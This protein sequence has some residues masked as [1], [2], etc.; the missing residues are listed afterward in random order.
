[1]RTKKAFYN[2]VVSITYQLVAL[3]CGLIVPRMLLGAFGSTYNGVINSVAQFLSM[4]SILRLG[5]AGS[6]RVALY[7]T[8]AEN[9]TLGTSRLIKATNRYARKICLAIVFLSVLL[10]VFYPMISNNDLER[11]QTTLLIFIVSITT[12]A[13]YFFGFTYSTLLQADQ[14]EYVYSL[15]HIVTTILNAILVIILIRLNCNVFTVKFGSAIAYSLLPVALS[16]Y[17]TKKYHITSDCE[18]DDSAL[19]KRG[20]VMF[21]SIANIVHGN[22]DIVLLTLFLDAKQ[23]SVYTVYYLVIGKIR[24]LTQVFTSGL[25]AA[26]GNMWAKNETAALKRNFRLYEFSMFSFVSVIFSCVGL[27]IVPF[28]QL[29][30]I[31]VTD[32]NYL[33]AD[34]AILVTITEGLFCLRA[35]YVTLVQATNHYKETKTGAAVEAIANFSVS[36]LLVGPLG[37]NGVII[38]TFT[39]NLIRTSQYAWFASAHILN[40]PIGCVVKRLACMLCCVCANLGVGCAL[41]RGLSVG[42][43][44]GGWVVDGFAVFTASVLITGL[45]SLLFYRDDLLGMLGVAKRMIRRKAK[46]EI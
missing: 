2:I 25:E 19:K 34:F 29:Y 32:T 16:I 1:M 28:I 35:P 15:L 37:L 10:A 18:P 5:V 30:T 8:L 44:W 36:L 11:H 46:D 39:A 42:V 6:T 33:L 38:G 22:T 26:F 23:I 4:V 40:R 41:M 12:F 9:D 7:K 20:D 3:V 43:G 24:S 31:H 27:L 21:H 14:S 17:C 45:F 13:E